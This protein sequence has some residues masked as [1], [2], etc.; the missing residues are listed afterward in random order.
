MRTA[1]RYR[2]RSAGNLSLSLRVRPSHGAGCL[3]VMAQLHVMTSERSLF[4]A[5]ALLKCYL[6]TQPL[7]QSSAAGAYAARIW[8][9]AG[10]SRVPQTQS[11]VRWPDSA[12]CAHAQLRDLA[13]ELCRRQA[14]DELPVAAPTAG[15]VGPGPVD[16][17][18]GARP[19]G[20]REDDEDCDEAVAGAGGSGGGGVG[21]GLGPDPG[22]GRSRGVQASLDRYF[23]RASARP[24]EDAGDPGWAGPSWP[25]Q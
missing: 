20:A 17:G 19:G 8:S 18:L 4:W 11:D 22:R 9:L 2:R 16:P 25:S 5:W 14:A 3:R 23:P 7:S 1:E 6:C 21:T 12:Q 15:A 24:P 13:L 10:A